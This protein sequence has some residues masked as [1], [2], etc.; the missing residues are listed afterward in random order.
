M[1]LWVVGPYCNA[2]AN[3]VNNGEGN[4]FI[5]SLPSESVVIEIKSHYLDRRWLYVLS[6][7][8]VGWIFIN[9]DLGDRRLT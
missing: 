8:G 4:E 6:C 5:F 7:A 3:V 9:E 2:F 1:N